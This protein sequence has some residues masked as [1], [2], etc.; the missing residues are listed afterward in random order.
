MTTTKSYS[1]EALR[2]AHPDAWIAVELGDTLD[3]EVVDVTEAWSDVRQGGSFYPLLTVRTDDEIELKVHCFGAVLYSEIMRHRPEIGERIHIRYLGQGKAKQ[4]GMNPPEL[5]RVRL[6]GRRHQ[7][8]TTYDRIEGDARGE[9]SSE[10]DSD[11][12]ADATDLPC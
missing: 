8:A 7:A 4:R 6:P 9:G 3:G 10:P 11:I 12:P 2:E 5:Y 1:R